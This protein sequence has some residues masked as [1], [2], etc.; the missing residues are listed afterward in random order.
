MG[1]HDHD[2][3]VSDNFEGAYDATSY[4]I[5]KEHQRI[6]F[7]SP[8]PETNPNFSQRRDGFLKAL[9]DHDL[10]VPPE[11]NSAQDVVASI[12]ALLRR[13]PTITAVLGCNDLYT[14]EAMKV[15][16]SLGRQVPEEF[17]CIGFDDVELATATSPQLTTMAVDKISMG[18]LAV[19][20]LSYRIAWPNAARVL[21]VL[22]PELIERDSVASNLAENPRA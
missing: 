15:A 10:D 22:R 20:A 6:G 5:A 1:V 8:G 21:T 18:R 7:V 17:S 11:M 16:Q 3:V 12:E 2:A 13:D 19:Q 9:I 4:L 14:I